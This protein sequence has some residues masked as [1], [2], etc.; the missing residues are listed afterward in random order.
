MITDN[1]RRD[2]IRLEIESRTD[3]KE[4]FHR[5]IELL[6]VL[7]GMLEVSVAG[8]KTTLRPNDIFLVNSNKPHSLRS[9]EDVLFAKISILY[10]LIGDVIRE[11]HVIF[12][13]DSTKEES[14]K[15]SELR[16]TIL[17]LLKNYYDNQMDTGSF[18]HISLSYK[19]MDLLSKEFSLKKIHS[20]NDGDSVDVED[21]I[22]EINDYIQQNYRQQVGIKDL[23]DQLYLSV[24]YLSRFFKKYFG[25]SFTEY[26]NQ[27]RLYYAMDELMHTDIPVTAVAFNNGFSSLSNFNRVFKEEYGET[28]TVFRKKNAVVQKTESK[29]E[30]IPNKRLGEILWG[31][32]EEPQDE[33]MRS[34]KS[35]TLI[36]KN[37]N[38]CELLRPIWNQT[39]NIG[40]AED[41]MRSEVREHI[42]LLKGALKFEYVR[43]FHLFSK[44]MLI[45]VSGETEHQNFSRIDSVLDF[46][47]EQGLKPHIDIGGKTK[48]I[49]KS[50]SA[51]LMQENI[52]ETRFT[53][54]WLTAFEGFI[55]HISRRYGIDE[56]NQWRIEIWDKNTEYAN[57]GT[58]EELRRYF[59]NF[60][61]IKQIVRTYSK[62][63]K[64][65]G[66]G[67]PL[68]EREIACMIPVLRE[69]KEWGL[70]P[71]FISFHSYPYIVEHGE[72]GM[73]S[74]ASSDKQ[75]TL[76]RLQ[77]V[78]KLLKNA[79]LEELDIFLTEWNL[80]I[81][82]RN[83]INDTSF[84]AA[85][86]MQNYIDL[87]GELA[88]VD[89]FYGT[90][91]VTEYYDT[92]EL[93]YGGSGLLTRDGM[94]K[95]VGFAFYFLNRL[96][97]YFISKGSNY[98]ATV[99]K[100]GDFSIVCQ[101]TSDLSYLYYQ[102]DE[103]KLD[104]KLIGKYFENEKQLTLSFNIENME[105]GAYQV[106]KYQINKNCGSIFTMWQKMDF[107]REFSRDDIKYFR[108]ICEPSLSMQKMTVENGKAKFDVILEADEICLLRIKRK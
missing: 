26:I 90:D 105:N 57:S 25:M 102:T 41:M 43:I 47:L 24:G 44:A 16:E 100:N 19:I 65:G 99:D 72:D 9:G 69:Y 70:L 36:W 13:C 93:L 91:R 18:R 55:H 32:R 75:Y 79:D 17:L 85:Y 27:I 38:T 35:E 30:S 97:P 101:N 59:A 1:S 7:D 42:M 21:R 5:D 39:I 48:R 87:Y 82:D 3:G 14:G 66:R 33:S 50:T 37:P 106:K 77:E 71:D 73:L 103:E 98:L 68:T 104:Y 76:Q 20:E 83:F 29:E 22:L 96:K 8:E 62:E 45:D 11:K 49:Q 2:K 64:I 28:P 63:M 51:A 94:M 23:A 80:T 58:E 10:E 61:R 52:T 92:G 89:Y 46:I 67:G 108:R 60:I 6:Y 86:T 31:V 54:A 107:E 88:E 81:S 56:I 34:F 4:H 53:E 95:P 40:S 84:K 12:W 15:Y 74:R 78:K